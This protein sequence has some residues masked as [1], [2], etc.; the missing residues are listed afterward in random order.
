MYVEDVGLEEGKEGLK[1]SDS[2]QFE[3]FGILNKLLL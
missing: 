3:F 2:K 1:F